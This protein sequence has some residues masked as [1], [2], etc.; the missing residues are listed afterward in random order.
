MLGGRF[1]HRFKVPQVVGYIIVGVVMGKSLLGF[2]PVVALDNF[3]PLINFTLGV[4]GFLIGAELKSDVFCRYGRSIYFILIGEGLLAFILVFAAVTLI[5]GKPYLGLLFGAIASA[6]DPASTVNVLWEYKSR[7]PLTT[8]LTSIVAL[9]DG[10][11]LVLYGLVSVFSRAMIANESASLW[12]SVCSPLLELAKCL[13]IGGMMAVLL[14]WLIKRLEKKSVLA[15]SIGAVAFV[16][17]LSVYLRLDLILTSMVM[18]AVIVNV[19]P[20][21]G[22]DLFKKI[23]EVS[24]SLYIFFFVFVGASLDIRVFLQSSLLVVILGYLLSRGAGKILGA[25]LGAYFSRAKKSVLRYGGVCLFTQGGVAIGLAMSIAHNLGSLGRQGSEVGN[26]VINV[27]AATTFVVQL[28]GPIFVKWGITSADEAGRNV[29][30]EDIIASS[31]VGDFM[32]RDF[33][34]VRENANLNKIMDTV[35]EGES[36]YLP[37]VDNDNRLTGLISLGELRG[38]FRETQ[39]DNVILA[40]DVAVPVAKVLYPD[41]P[42]KEAFDVFDR[43]EIDYLPVVRDEESRKIVGILEY[44]SLVSHVSRKTLEQQEKLDKVA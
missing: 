40:E 23:K 10:L 19:I 12:A 5:T 33:S 16:V 29:T 41:H 31:L 11:A 20:E 37:V 28:V 32:F 3:T 8:T 22:D 4:I 35:K 26:I 27:V 13:A 1:L 30:E 21:V 42:L 2:F 39:V 18:G 25:M 38:V 44:H 36:Y 9:D 17:G 34:Y 24:T 15:L 6:T 7:G 43:R 14:S